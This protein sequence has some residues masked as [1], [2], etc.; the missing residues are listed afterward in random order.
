M[1]KFF[2]DNVITLEDQSDLPSNF[3]V[4]EDCGKTNEELSGYCIAV[5]K[6]ASEKVIDMFQIHDLNNVNH[7]KALFKA[8]PIEAFTIVYETV[9]REYNGTVTQYLCSR[10]GSIDAIFEAFDYRYEDE[11]EEVPITHERYVE[12]PRVVT[13]VAAPIQ[14]PSYR[15]EMDALV[16]QAKHNLAQPK[17]ERMITTDIEDDEEEVLVDEVASREEIL[18]FINEIKATGAYQ[19]FILDNIL[20]LYDS[21]QPALATEQVLELYQN[22]L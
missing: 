2:V 13:P 12:A 19:D 15:E 8:K 11:I 5:D 4:L 10:Y 20:R 22:T 9:V 1:I 14:K 17:E 6:G 7:I 21:G 18:D 3:I 16:K